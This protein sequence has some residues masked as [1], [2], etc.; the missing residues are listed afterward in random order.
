MIPK[1]LLL[2]HHHVA[3]HSSVAKGIFSGNC[4]FLT[5]FLLTLK[6]AI[7]YNII[8]L[9]FISDLDE[10]IRKKTKTYQHHK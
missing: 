1:M 8:K 10:S 5:C 9:F 6:F 7:N 4:R 3:V 2:W